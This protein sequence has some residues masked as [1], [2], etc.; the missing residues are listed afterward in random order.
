[1]TT[2]KTGYLKFGM[3]PQ[4]ILDIIQ[5]YYPG[6]YADLSE[7]PETFYSLEKLFS[8]EEWLDILMKSRLSHEQ[9]SKFK[10]L[11]IRKVK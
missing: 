8:K 5:T 9:W 2:L 7:G 1:M 6:R 3:Y 4:G 11:R 10:K